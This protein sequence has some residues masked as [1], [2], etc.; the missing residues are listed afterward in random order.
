MA[1]EKGIFNASSN[2]EPL[3]GAPFDARSLVAYKSDLIDPDS[4]V[5]GKKYLYNGMLVSVGKDTDENNGL[6]ILKDRLNY[7]DYSAWEKIADITAINSLQ[8][9]IDELKQSSGGGGSTELEFA[10]RLNF[11]NTGTDGI[12]YIATDENAAY[13][14][15]SANGTYKCVGR[16]YHEIETIFGGN[17]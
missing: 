1:R 16:D 4:W 17:A 9:Q 15:N 14:W 5:S 11:P 3:I 7:T 10:T 8:T 13:Y 2:Y 6:Y 12:L